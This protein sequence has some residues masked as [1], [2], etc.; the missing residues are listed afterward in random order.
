MLAG[1]EAGVRHRDAQL[2]WT[3]VLAL[4]IDTSSA[5]VTAGIVDIGTGVKV[6]AETVTVNARAHGELLAP[7]IKA[8]LE[9]TNLTPSR[10]GAI[11]VGTGPGPFTGLR[12]GLV[13]AAA[14]A[15]ALQIPAYG[16]CSLNGIAAA[17]AYEGTLLVAG[18]ARRKEVY[19]A[20]YV[21]GIPD[22]GPQVSKPA[23]LTLDA[24]AMAGAGAR[25]YR[26]VLGLP[27]LDKDYPTVGGLAK[28]A[29]ERVRS[30]AA[31][32]PLTPLYLRRPDAVPPAERVAG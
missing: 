21:D 23:D 20:R 6:L 17:I 28:V 11:V 18:D 15:D 8:S 31:P 30:H 29:V 4:V 5:A 2:G 24:S 16:V 27:L 22:G 12:V 10:L 14:M 26:D 3:I 7:S 32:D 1:A 25:L 13:T 19:W 9:A